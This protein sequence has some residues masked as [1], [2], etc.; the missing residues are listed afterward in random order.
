MNCKQKRTFFNLFQIYDCKTC[1]YQKTDEFFLIGNTN[2]SIYYLF[3]DCP[4]VE[5]DKEFLYFTSKKLKWLLLDAI[6]YQQEI[7]V[8]F[9]EEFRLEKYYFILDCLLNFGLSIQIISG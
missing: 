5:I 2:I 7:L 9:I 8:I 3:G 4:N 1:P 6:I